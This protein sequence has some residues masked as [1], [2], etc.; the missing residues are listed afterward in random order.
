MYLWMTEWH[1][2][3]RSMYSLA[4]PPL[5][6]CCPT[7]DASRH[8]CSVCVSVVCVMSEWERLFGTVDAWTFP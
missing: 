8:N 2:W 4:P 3:H 6:L 1:S 5:P 7:H